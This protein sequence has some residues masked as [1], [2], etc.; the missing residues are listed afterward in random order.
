M[1]APRVRSI[2]N[3]RPL[4]APR[5]TSASC[6]EET[7]TALSFDVSEGRSDQTAFLAT[8]KAKSPGE[9]PRSSFLR[10]RDR[11]L[12]ATGLAA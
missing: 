4:V 5:H 6:Q 1:W 11:Y 10:L 8:R 12:Y 7:F 9:E 2:S 3:T